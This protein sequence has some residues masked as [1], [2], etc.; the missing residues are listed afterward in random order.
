MEAALFWHHGKYGGAA[1]NAD[2]DDDGLTNLAEWAGGLNPK[3]SGSI[4]AG[5]SITSLRLEY[6]Y[7]RSKPAMAEGVV[8]AVEWSESMRDGN[9]TALG[10]KESVLAEEGDVE[11][12]SASMSAT[13]GAGGRRFIRLRITGQ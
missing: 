7:R 8:L 1:D 3:A 13:A 10:V 11:T 6:R 12:V 2:P 5:V 9:W 4:T